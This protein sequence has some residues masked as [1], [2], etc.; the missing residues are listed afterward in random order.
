VRRKSTP[1]R[2]IPTELPPDDLPSPEVLDELLRAFSADAAD[3]QT[4][5]GIDLASPEV[6]ELIAPSGGTPTP[7]PVE[8]P[9]EPEV[10]AER[11]ADLM[12]EPHVEVKT[13]EPP[14]HEFEAEP[15]LALEV[16]GS[17]APAQPLEVDDGV[18]PQP[19]EVAERTDAAAPDD[20]PGPAPG[21]AARTVVIDASDELPDAVYLAAGDPLLNAPA[22][23]VPTGV[24]DT[25]RSRDTTV[26]IDD[27][28]VEAGETISI[29]DAS[30]ATRIEPR[31]RE[32]RIAVK[33][34]VGRKRLRWVVVVAAVLA[35]VVAV[36]AMLGSS[37]FAIDEVRVDGAVRAD[38]ARLQAVVDELEGR[39]VLRADVDAAE[40]ELEAIPWVDSAR[41]TTQ[42]PNRA[43]VELR[44]RSAV[45]AYVG[46]DGRFRVIDIEGRVLEVVDELPADQL[47]IE[48]PDAIDLEPGQFSAQGFIAAANLV[49][50][51]TPEAR[52]VATGVTVTG[53]G[54]DLRLTLTDGREVRFGPGRDLVV[55]LVRLQTKLL[56]PDGPGFQYLDVSTDDVTT[57]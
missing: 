25:D 36:L 33:R 31:L 1:G 54:G 32:R 40:R 49:Q 17:G 9:P 34:A 29:A 22:G 19:P 48:S 37:L 24:V 13:S 12:P 38:P 51:L 7:P 43:T 44:E 23:R 52:A 35:V 46:S 30:S 6:A 57:G 42:F 28:A 5:Q 47:L 18:V 4:L 39:P 20:P 27:Q 26:F 11:R 16:E 8:P 55:K 56:E 41:V 10:E 14:E 21:S 53:N 3:T 45:A 2:S 15:E 50:A